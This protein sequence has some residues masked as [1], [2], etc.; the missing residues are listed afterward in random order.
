MLI[1]VVVIV[2]YYIVMLLLWKNSLFRRKLQLHCKS[3]VYITVWICISLYHTRLHVPL[4]FICHQTRAI[5]AITPQLQSI[6]AYW[7]VLIEPTHGG[8]ARLS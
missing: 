3:N 2:Y 7:L 4:S 1:I 5:S 8:M 6:I